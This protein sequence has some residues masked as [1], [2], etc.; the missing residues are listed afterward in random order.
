MATPND[1]PTAQQH[2]LSLNEDQFTTSTFEKVNAVTPIANLHWSLAHAAT[3]DASMLQR[4]KAM[5]A[6]VA[7]HP[8]QYLRAGTGKPTGAGPPLRTILESGVHAGAGSDGALVTVLDPWMII[9]YMVTGRNAAGKMINDG[10]QIS[11]QDALRL[12]TAE[13]GWFT[14]EE[15]KIGSIV[16]GQLGD[17]V[18]LSGDY[19]DP[20]KVPDESI[21]HLKSALTIV[22]GRVVYD[23]LH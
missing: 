16:P 14:H 18:V 5:G 1:N 8:A 7:V 11:R 12:Y 20:A 17:L 2:T 13:N 4:L 22:G 21:R 10:Q 9:S 15:E 19:F 3:I 23:N 6:G